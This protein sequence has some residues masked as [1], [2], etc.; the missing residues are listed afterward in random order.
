MAADNCTVGHAPYNLAPILAEERCKVVMDGRSRAGTLSVET[1]ATADTPLPK[2]NDGTE[3]CAICLDTIIDATEVSEGEDALFCDRRCACITKARFDRISTSEAPFLCHDCEAEAQCDAID[4]LQNEAAAL[5]AEVVELKNALQEAENRAICLTD[6]MPKS[7][8]PEPE[9]STSWSTAVQRGSKG[10]QSRPHQQRQNRN[11]RLPTTGH[12]QVLDKPVRDKQPG[13]APAKG[14]DMQPVLGK[15][16]IWGTLKQ[17]NAGAVQRAIH[18]F[19]TVPDSSIEVRR[20]YKTLKNAKQRWWYVLKAEEELLQ[21]LDGEWEGVKLQTGWK[22]EPCLAYKDSPQSPPTPQSPIP[23][24]ANA[25]PST[26][27]T[28]VVTNPATASATPISPDPATTTMAPNSQAP[29]PNPE[30]SQGNGQSPLEPTPVGTNFQQGI[31]Q[32]QQ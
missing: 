18:Q 19:P 11:S 4:S 32:E 31:P 22:L 24:P 28:A 13:K 8:N 20:K 27:S 1:V 15:R 5:R 29:P 3:I 17:C 30:T 14:R 23:S 16:R 10:K 12:E 2:G 6:S 7:S 9:Q 26:S 25:E 21:R